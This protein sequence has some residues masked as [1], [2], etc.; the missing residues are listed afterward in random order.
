MT[1]QPAPCAKA[2]QLPGLTFPSMRAEQG[3]KIDGGLRQRRAAVVNYKAP[4]HEVDAFELNDLKLSLVDL[5]LNDIAV[6]NADTEAFLHRRFD[7]VRR[8]AAH[9]DVE[10]EPAPAE[11]LEELFARAAT[12]VVFANHQREFF[13]ALERQS[14][15]RSDGM[16]F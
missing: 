13:D 16:I 11:L 2:A 10:L 7:R 14:R 9:S 8:V 15:A 3:Q 12:V 6:D 5:G 1:D 4:A